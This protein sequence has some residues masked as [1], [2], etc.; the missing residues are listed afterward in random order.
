MSASASATISTATVAT[1]DTIYKGNRPTEFN[2]IVT[3]WKNYFTQLVGAQYT[4]NVMPTQGGTNR[5]ELL[6]KT[7]ATGQL[8]LRGLVVRRNDTEALD[9]AGQSALS[10]AMPQGQA[11]FLIADG[12]IKFYTMRADGLVLDPQ[13]SPIHPINGYT[14]V[15]DKVLHILRRKSIA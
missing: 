6:F 11:K 9:V 10:N 7:V 5:T 8:R 2:V 3:F 13:P 15:R 12:M 14:E 4:V 1:W